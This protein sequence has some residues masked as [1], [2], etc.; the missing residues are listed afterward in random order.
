MRLATGGDRRLRDRRTDR[1]RRVLGRLPG[2]TAV[3]EPRG[4]DQ[5]AQHRVRHRR[6]A[7]DVRARVPRPRAALA[8]PQHRH[9]VRRRDHRRRPAVHRDG[10]VPPT[11]REQLERDRAAADRRGCSPSACASAGRCRP[12]TTHGVLHRDIKPH[13]IFLSAYGEPALG[14]FGIST[15]DDERSHSG[16]SGLSVAYAAPEVLE[17]GRASPRP[18]CT[19]WRPRSTTW[20]PARRR[21]RAPT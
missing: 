16:A 1:I 15:I 10:A 14:D 11:Y 21:S 2:P 4:R 12:P 9:R 13:N 18:T 17:D 20:S 3:D 6:R 5:G 7:A 8:P 19:R